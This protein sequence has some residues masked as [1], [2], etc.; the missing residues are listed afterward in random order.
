[1]NGS[2]GFNSRVNKGSQQGPVRKH[3]VML[4]DGTSGMVHIF[5]QQSPVFQHE[6]KDL[7]QVTI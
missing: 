2:V 6:N 4:Q 3:E 7:L 5:C 1:M